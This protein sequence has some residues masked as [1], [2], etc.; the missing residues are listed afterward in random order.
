MTRTVNKAP[1]EKPAI[2]E[3][4]DGASVAFARA[5][6][7]IAEHGYIFSRTNTPYFF[8]M[9]GHVTLTLELGE[10]SEKA[11]EEAA[12]AIAS[13]LAAQKAQQ[14]HDELKAMALARESEE[15]TAKQAEL[16]EQVRAAKAQLK[17]L[18]AAQR[19]L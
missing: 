6:V 15:R 11:V 19:S 10:H 7:L 8:T 13:T 17:K 18:E 9:T 16:A 1:T 14:E 2:I 5:A 4:C 12:A 3:I